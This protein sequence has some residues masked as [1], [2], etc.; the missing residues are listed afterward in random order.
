MEFE[1]DLKKP[2]AA[3][4]S[5]PAEYHGFYTQTDD[6]YVVADTHV[7]IA[8]NINGL[9]G[10]LKKARSSLTEANSESADRRVKL[11]GFTSLFDGLEGIEEQTPEALKTFID[12][13]A[14][15]AAAGGKTSEETAAALEAAKRAITEKFTAEKA[16]LQGSVD[17]LTGE[18]RTL[19]I[20]NRTSSAIQAASGNSALLAPMLEKECEIRVT[21]EG[22]RVVVVLGE[23][24][25]PRYNG[26]GD[27]LT[28]EQR[29]A[30]IKEDERF[31]GAFQGQVRSGADT[32]T[33]KRIASRV[34][35][36][37]AKRSAMQNISAGLAKRKR[38]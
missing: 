6:G 31:Q 21:D 4:T 7:K 36:D 12:G 19:L 16:E 8:K 23:D 33:S 10:N 26:E 25:E 32:K 2:I 3:L 24:G 28:I 18:I 35:A 20:D 29:V 22:Q 5:V 30:E 38:G 1:F 11:A 9:S 15:Q 37:P 34:D 14:E 17:S 13:L 27:L